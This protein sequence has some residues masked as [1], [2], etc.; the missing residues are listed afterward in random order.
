MNFYVMVLG[1]FSPSS[2]H[3]L[4]VGFCQELITKQKFAVHVM[5]TC[6]FACW[7]VQKMITDSLIT[8]AVLHRVCHT[9]L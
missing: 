6:K 2:L 4:V 5:I 7:C 1:S 9:L 3:E 8:H